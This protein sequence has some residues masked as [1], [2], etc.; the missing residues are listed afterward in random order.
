MQI[1]ITTRP[2]NTCCRMDNIKD[3]GNTKLGLNRQQV[4]H[5]GWECKL[6]KPL[7]KADSVC[8]IYAYFIALFHC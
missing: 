4:S 8:Y 5:G 3:S 2:H 1:Q 6:A 7:W